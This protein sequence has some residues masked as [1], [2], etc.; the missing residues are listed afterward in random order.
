MSILHGVLHWALQS[1]LWCPVGESVT[2][3][4]PSHHG[5]YSFSSISCTLL[6]VHSHAASAPLVKECCLKP[7]IYRRAHS[8]GSDLWRYNTFPH[9]DRKFQNIIV[10]SL[11]VYGNMVDSCKNKGFLYQ[12]VCSQPTMPFPISIKETWPSISLPTPPLIYTSINP[13][14]HLSTNPTIHPSIH[15]SI[16]PPTGY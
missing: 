12:E 2:E 8:Q 7:E 5:T 15:P 3:T 13:P 4:N 6:P 11:E 10:V 9:R 14:I 16:H 1:L